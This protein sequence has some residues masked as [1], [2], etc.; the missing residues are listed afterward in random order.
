VADS[1]DAD[2]ELVRVSNA[3]W[4]RYDMYVRGRT[5]RA[6]AAEYDMTM[7]QVQAELKRVT[8]AIPPEAVEDVRRKHLEE[9]AMA[10]R[11]MWD[12]FGKDGSPVTAGK[13]GDVVYDPESGE[14]VREYGLRLAATDKIL[15]IQERVS[16][17]LGLDQ[18][19]KVELSVTQG[20]SVDSE[21]AALAL[22]LGIPMQ[23][24]SERV[25]EIDGSE[26]EADAEEVDAEEADHSEDQ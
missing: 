6:I 3:A 1:S 15:K 19:A 17:L 8:K 21:M 10:T 5:V 14:I 26:E 13:D 12:L 18:A 16:K 24:Q 25:V 4:D 2:L 20:Q 9:L 11:G 22:Q 23:A 7:A